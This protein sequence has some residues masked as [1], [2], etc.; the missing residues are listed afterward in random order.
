MLSNLKTAFLNIT[1]KDKKE[2]MYEGEDVQAV[3][4]LLSEACQ[5]DGDTGKDELQYIKKLLVNK[6]CFTPEQA[7]KKIT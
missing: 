2:D 1:S 6:F 7:A 4:I 3:I 5:I